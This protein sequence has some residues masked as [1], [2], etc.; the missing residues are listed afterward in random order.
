MRLVSTWQQHNCNSYIVVYALVPLVFID[1]A[2]QVVWQ[3]CTQ[4]L[5]CKCGSMIMVSTSRYPSAAEYAWKILHQPTQ[6]SQ[7]LVMHLVVHLE[8]EQTIIDWDDD[9]TELSSPVQRAAKECPS[10]MAWFDYNASHTECSHLRL[11]YHHFHRHFVRLGARS[12]SPKSSCSA[13]PWARQ[14]LH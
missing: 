10:R 2:D 3:P 5:F 13:F 1:H 4:S 12:G 6:T 8:D 11:L 14:R 7:P 9:Q